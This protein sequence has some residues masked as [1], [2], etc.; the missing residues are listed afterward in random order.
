MSE[1]PERLLSE[2]L[3]AQARN[4]PPPLRHAA[5][6]GPSGPS[7]PTDRPGA[8]TGLAGGYGL[9]SGA[10]HDSLELRRAVSGLG[11]DEAGSR[12]ADHRRASGPLATRWLL[13]LAGSLG[14]AVGS[15]L[16][17]LTL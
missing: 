3:R 2:A 10:D 9:L 17:L 12:Q 6:T 7:G 15:V 11:P 1:N 16:G 5:S 14:F 13:L 8:G 4:A